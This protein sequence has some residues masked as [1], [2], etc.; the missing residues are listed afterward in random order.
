MISI[1]WKFE[2]DLKVRSMNICETFEKIS[3][4]Y[5]ERLTT[6]EEVVAMEQYKNNLQL[7]MS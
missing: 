7:D 3:V 4:K 2:C 6:A 5:K 1:L